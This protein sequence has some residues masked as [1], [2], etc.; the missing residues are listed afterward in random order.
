MAKYRLTYTLLAFA[1]IGASCSQEEINR[2]DNTQKGRIEF[3][4]SLPEVTSRATELT[5]ESLADLTVSSFIVGSS[6]ET[7]YFMAKTFSRNAIT[8][9]FLSYDPDCIWPNNNDLI[10]FMAFAPS[11]DEMRQTGSFDDADFSLGVAEDGAYKF[12]GVKIAADIA[13][14]FDFVTAIGSGK[15]RD[16]EETPVKL[17]FRHQL[18]R[19][20]LKAWGASKSYNIEIAGVRLGGVGTEGVFSFVGHPDADD[21]SAAGVWESVSKGCVEYIYRPGDRIVVLDRSEISPLSSNNSVSIMGRQVGSDKAYDNSA[22]LIPSNNT[23]WDYKA[24]AANGDE[25]ADGMYFSVLMRITDI[26]PYAPENPL[27]YP[28]PEDSGNAVGM[29]VIYLAVDN[30]GEV[31]AR[32]YKKDGAYYTDEEY[33]TAYAGDDAVKAFGWAALPVTD[34]WNPGYVYTY[35]LNYTYGVGLRDPHDSK[36]GDPIISDKVLINVEVSPWKS[37]EDKNVSVP[38]K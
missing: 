37:G 19:I 30:Q 14:Q 8:G 18:S 5:K 1:L 36:P 2:P 29:E 4:A 7:P 23:S 12:S 27:V 38:R 6:S 15:L 16:N 21:A 32:L 22:M 26:T 31:K 34:T 3:S 10:R 25:H 13:D 20:E 33:T 11:C 17:Q 9:T 35:T 24:N 28:Y